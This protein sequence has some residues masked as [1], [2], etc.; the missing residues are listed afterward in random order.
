[1]L[2]ASH[3]KKTFHFNFRAR[4]SRGLLKDKTSWFIKVWDDKEPAVFGLGEC[5]PLPGLSVDSKPDF[6]QVLDETVNRIQSVQRLSDDA[7]EMISRMV[8]LGYPSIKFGVETAIRDLVNGGHRIIFKNKFLDGHRVPINGLIWMD[9]MDIMLQQI[10]DKIAQGFTCIKI[11]VGGLNFERECDILHYIRKKYFR[12][13]ITIRL[14]ANG[15]FKPEDALSKI[16]QLSRFQVHS[17]E[18]PLKPG[19]ESLEELCRKT[20]VPIALDEE[21]IGLEKVEEKTR[22]LQKIKPQFITLKPTLH[23]GF[24][25]CQEWIDIAQSVNIG[26]W[27]TSALESNIGLNAIS[28]FTASFENIIPQGLGTGLLYADNFPSPLTIEQGHIYHNHKE[29]WDVSEFA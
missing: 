15:A 12:D 4:T 22:L 17:I 20:P 24:S 2:R 19:N 7:V 11:K 18:Q 27:I 23:G 21:L 26:W 5:G 9:D 16:T 28:Q 6:E 8:P 29:L 3:T 10:T 13:Q 25:G 14:D 1:M